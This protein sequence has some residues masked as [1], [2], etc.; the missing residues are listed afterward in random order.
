MVPA[1]DFAFYFVD[2]DAAGNGAAKLHGQIDE[3]RQYLARIVRHFPGYILHRELLAPR[4]DPIGGPPGEL[5][6]DIDF[7][8]GVGNQQQAP[9]YR[10]RRARNATSTM[11]NAFRCTC[12]KRCFRPRIRS[13]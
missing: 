4:I 10:A 3:R 2:A 9:F 6:G 8:N 12:G 7:G 5:V 13:R 11:V 1:E